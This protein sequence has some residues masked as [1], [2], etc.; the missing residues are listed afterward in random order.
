MPSISRYN[1]VN[2][3]G[4]NAGNNGGGNNGNFRFTKDNYEPP[5]TNTKAAREFLEN[6]KKMKEKYSKAELM[7]YYRNMK[8]F[9]FTSHSGYKKY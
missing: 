4:N 3:G 6:F 8:K 9:D 2:N 5:Q 7:A 1:G